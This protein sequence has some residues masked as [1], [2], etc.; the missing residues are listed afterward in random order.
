MSP[1]AFGNNTANTGTGLFGTTPKPA[2]GFG[3]FGGGGANTFGGGGAGAFGGAAA[4][5]SGTNG[6]FVQ[7]QQPAATNTFGT[8]GGLFGAKPATAFG[9][10][11]STAAGKLS[12]CYTINCLLIDNS[13]LKCR[14]I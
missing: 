2:T 3:A 10:A 12:Q 9:T 7:P 6:L 13:E 1:G 14:S 4:G 8:G 5:P 11:A